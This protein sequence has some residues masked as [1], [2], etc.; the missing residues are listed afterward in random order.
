MRFPFHR[1]GAGMIVVLMTAL[2]GIAQTQQPAAEAAKTDSISGKVVNESG[3]PLPNAAVQV[4]AVDAT[5]MSEPATTDREGTFKVN[6]LKPVP[7]RVSVYMPAYISVSPEPESAREKRYKVGDSLT[8]VLTKGGVI[9]G[10][11]T[12]G[13]GDPVVGINVRARM[14]RD[15]K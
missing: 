8:F 3:Q 1:H 6:G 11:V 7:Y 9:T 12:T 2:C 14:I 13:L 4:Q 10:I 15:D 5:R